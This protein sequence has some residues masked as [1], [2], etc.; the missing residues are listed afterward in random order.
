MTMRGNRVEVIYDVETKKL[1]EEISTNDPADLG[2]S[3]VSVYR[4]EVDDQG[5]EV[6]G[7]MKS[8]WTDE[9][10]DIFG[11]KELYFES[12][13]KWFEEADR[14]IGFNSFGFDNQAMNGIYTIGDFTKLKHFDILD[15]IKKALGFRVKLDSIAKET[16]GAGKNADGLD[17]VK[18]WKKR[19]L[20]SLTNLKKYCEMD[21]MVTTKVYDYAKEKGR[22]RF[23]DKWNEFREFEVDF[24]YPVEI[25]DIV[26][27]ETQ[28]GLF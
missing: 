27:A 25:K 8:F 20:V 21:V 2:I 19:D 6:S 7:E 13:W 5:K 1:F 14:I 9:V 15:E 10:K 4:R 26:P 11:E 24:S 16:I 3:V 12:M 22:L 18:W 23:K 17:A 28:M